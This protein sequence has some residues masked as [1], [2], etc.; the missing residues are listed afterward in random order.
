MIVLREYTVDLGDAED[1]K[2]Q[3]GIL[4]MWLDRIS[5]AIENIP[6]GRV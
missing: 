2:L 5:A 6:V 4:D 1:A 3:L